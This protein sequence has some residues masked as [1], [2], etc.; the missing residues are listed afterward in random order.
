MFPLCYIEPTS[1]DPLFTKA[2]L[3]DRMRNHAPPN[4][5][6]APAC[7]LENPGA[8]SGEVAVPTRIARQYRSVVGSW[9]CSALLLVLLTLLAGLLP[10]NAI[11]A[12]WVPGS[13]PRRLQARRPSAPSVRIQ[14]LEP[15]R[16]WAFPAPGDPERS[17][18]R[19]E[20]RS[21]FLDAQEALGQ[22]RLEEAEAL[23]TSLVD[24]Y[25]ALA[26][27]VLR[28]L[29][30]IALSRHDSAGGAEARARE[31]LEMVDQ[32]EA[33]PGAVQQGWAAYLRGRALLVLGRP[34]EAESAFSRAWAAR[35]APEE[36]DVLYH[37]GRACEAAGWPGEAY[38]HYRLAEEAG[39]GIYADRAA[40]AA[41]RLEPS[42]TAQ[43]RMVDWE[44]RCERIARRVDRRWVQETVLEEIDA[45]LETCRLTFCRRTLQRL[46]G[47]A[48]L[49]LN[50]LEEAEPL[51]LALLDEEAASGNPRWETVA[52][53]QK[54]LARK[55]R[56]ED[57]RRLLERFVEAGPGRDGVRAYLILAAMST[58]DGDWAA[59]ESWYRAV[60]EAF[61]GTEAALDAH[62]RLVWSSYRRR[63]P[64]LAR[65]LLLERLA[66]VPP[67]SEEE[68]QTRY[69]LARVLE[70]LAQPDRAAA[71]LDDVRH[72]FRATYYGVMAYW[73]L[74]GGIPRIRTSGPVP[75]PEDREEY[76][77]E[78][79]AEL[80]VSLLFPGFADRI[81]E[82]PPGPR[83]LLERAKELWLMGLSGEARLELLEATRQ[84]E[85]PPQVLWI[86][87]ALRH[88]MGSTYFGT[89]YAHRYLRTL[90]S[91]ADV[92]AELLGLAYP[93][94][95]RRA[96]VKWSLQRGLEPALV[97]ALILQ[98]S[99]FRP[100]IRSPA[101]ARGLMQIMPYTE[102]EICGWLGIRR[103]RT[104]WL[105]EPDFNLRLGTEY[106]RAMLEKFDNSLIRALASYNAGPEAVSRWTRRPGAPE[107][108]D[109]FAEE[110]PYP[111][112]RDYV[113]KVVRNLAGY[114][115]VY[116]SFL[117]KPRSPR[118]SGR[119]AMR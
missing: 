30:R 104:R 50:R 49:K 105:D 46:K 88:A 63:N 39:T 93:F 106:L 41:R 68:A 69:W 55:G 26:P 73:R 12:P 74:A 82:I 72:R 113:R 54:T 17:A 10:E 103:C 38:R 6:H 101:G 3:E 21:R 18:E 11:G 94:P 78:S 48:L 75:V 9:H 65:R 64:V 47:K 27:Y 57:R 29:A 116:G 37:Y 43:E 86:A 102:R 109:V 111:E 33:E 66:L 71:V 7:R 28:D 99:T 15:P 14:R 34:E 76:P 97:A 91:D 62:W 23:L 118:G 2:F 119:T 100:A 4:R 67:G 89:W 32:M 58:N 70:A 53:L 19:E 59:A 110:I 83:L 98:E 45:A 107:E 31:V 1:P 112:T 77:G 96:V 51:L 22:G 24:M 20:L 13:S 85:A 36:S 25:P 56:R 117:S 60:I 84:P 35:L 81:A 87:A 52:L 40:T 79:P 42:L 80:G 44:V 95:F 114:L 108:D 90:D 5:A 16:P 92:P 8:P 61:P 115:E